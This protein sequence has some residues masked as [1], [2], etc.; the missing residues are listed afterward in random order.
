MLATTMERE[1]SGH[2]LKAQT[3]WCG[4]VSALAASCAASQA[5]AR[6]PD[7]ARLCLWSP[8]KAEVVGERES[9]GVHRPGWEKRKQRIGSWVGD[10][11]WPG[12]GLTLYTEEHWEPPF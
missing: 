4:C 2:R 11:M 8:L 12:E 9:R 5:V 7:A 10:C 3:G 6:Q 1:K